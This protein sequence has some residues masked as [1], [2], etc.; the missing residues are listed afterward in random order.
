VD[1]QLL[2]DRGEVVAGRAG[3][4]VEGGGQ[5]GDGAVAARLG[6]DLLLSP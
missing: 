6:Q 2:D 5:L 1:V 3:G 4:E